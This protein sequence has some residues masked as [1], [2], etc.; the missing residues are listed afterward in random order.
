MSARGAALFARF[1]YPPNELGYCG[2]EGAEALLDQEATDEITRRARGFD[3]AWCYLEF[4]AEAVGCADP[5]DER[6]VSAYWMGG[7]LLDSIDPEALVTRLEDRFRGQLGGSWRQAHGR[8]LPHH[9]F[10]VFEVYPWAGLLGQAATAT[11]ITVLDRCRIRAGE[12]LTVRRESARVR[13]RP[14]VWTSEGLVLG[15]SHEEEVRWSVGGRSLIAPPEQGA[16]VALHW[17]WVAQPVTPEEARMIEELEARH[18]ARI[19]APRLTDRR[20]GHWVVT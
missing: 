17:D 4:L 11:A 3:G 5:L 15:E 14:L 6:V 13:C 16:L 2:P 18:R 8:A 12:V 1:A 20:S 7:E 9:S 10:Q 19:S